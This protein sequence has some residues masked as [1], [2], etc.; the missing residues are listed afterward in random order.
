MSPKDDRRSVSKPGISRRGVLR[1]LT[2]GAVVVGFDPVSRAWATQGE[3]AGGATSSGA[4]AGGGGLVGLPPLD[5]TLLTDPADLAAAADDYGHL[6]HRTP[7]AVL[8]PGSVHDV[9]AM[10]RF[11]YQHRL[12]VAARGQG[13]QTFGQ[14]QVAGGLVIDMSPLD[15]ISI[16]GSTAT[17]QAGA[18]W[19]DVLNAAIA[20]GLTPPVFPDYVHLSLGGTLSAGGVGGASQHF[21]AQVDTVLELQVATGTGDLLACSATERPDL[22][23]AVL[24]GL[25]QCGV[26]ISA[27]VA[28]R[29]APQS[30]R[31]YVLNYPTVDALTADQRKVVLDGRFDWLEGQA[32]VSGSGGAGDW[33]YQ[34]EGAAYYDG[35]P[36]DDSALIGDLDYLAGTAVITDM[37][38]TDFVTILDPVVA[39][40]QSTGEWYD[41]HPWIDLFLPDTQADALITATMADLGE[42][43]IGASGVVLFYPV[44][45]ARFTHPLLRMPDGELTFLFA[46]LRTASPDTDALP[47]A[48][49][50]ADNEQLYL[51]ARS[52]G[53]L[54]YAI[55]S[56]PMTHADWL[57]QYGPVWP[58]FAAA[59]SRFDPRRILAPGQGI[60]PE[61]GG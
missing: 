16:S 3:A 1:G 26:I 11:C 32:A 34:L 55:D 57:E 37:D 5:G 9:T 15:Q 50:L 60:F 61:L 24:S 30:V 6:V 53:A 39:I 46:V 35:T 12:P 54:R 23:Q 17:A 8:Q 51:Q 48:T 33:V 47:A 10:L 22:F 45:R 14:A 21:G 18:T 19:F 42:N 29:P 31:Q 13:H 20:Q 43:D 25:G 58:Q 27:T 4:A 40:L 7:L 41:P 2:A 49:M 52:V 28:L 44:P 38:Y 36:P 56:V 59:K